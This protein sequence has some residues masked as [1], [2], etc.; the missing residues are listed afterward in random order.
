MRN[1]YGEFLR[2]ARP[3]TFNY[4]GEMLPGVKT[5]PERRLVETRL[6]VPRAESASARRRVSERVQAFLGLPGEAG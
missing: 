5:F 4:E 2:N 6:V 3:F 1:P